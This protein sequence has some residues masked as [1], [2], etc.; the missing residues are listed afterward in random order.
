MN[1]KISLLE[2]SKKQIDLIPELMKRGININACDLSR[3]LNDNVYHTPKM[4]K[5]REISEEIIEAWKSE[6]KQNAEIEAG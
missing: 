4:Q 3:A 5:V 2:L 1:I 6:V